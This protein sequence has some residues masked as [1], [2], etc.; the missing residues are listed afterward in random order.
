MKRLKKYR[1][2]VRFDKTLGR[3][4]SEFG[5]GQIFIAI[6]TAIL[7]GVIIGGWEILRDATDRSNTI[8]G[9]AI[10][11]SEGYIKSHLGEPQYKVLHEDLIAEEIFVGNDNITRVF[12]Q[13]DRLVGFFVTVLKKNTSYG[14]EGIISKFLNGKSIG[15]TCYE[16]IDNS[17]DSIYSYSSNGV[18]YTV[19]SECYYY[20]SIGYYHSYYFMYLDYGYKNNVWISKEEYEAQAEVKKTRI[21]TIYDFP[22]LSRR[23]SFPNTYGVCEMQCSQKL[24]EYI[25]DYSNFDF[26]E[27]R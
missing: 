23:E 22:F 3:F 17:P 8:N 18:G 9:L 11:Q 21:E 5:T 27:Y 10:G 15:R 16:E 19:Y 1:N 13:D 4:F 24:Y 12:F 25:C 7:V 20:G 14:R 2:I 6:F 26:S